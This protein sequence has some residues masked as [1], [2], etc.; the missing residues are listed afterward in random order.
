MTKQKI[1]MPLAVKVMKIIN[2]LMNNT[3]NYYLVYQHQNKINKLKI[4]QKIPNTKEKVLQLENY[5][6]IGNFPIMMI[7][8]MMKMKIIPKKISMKIIVMN[9][10]I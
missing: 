6:I 8:Q 2:K 10:K 1:Q 7:F 5:L 3:K 9:K 4:Y